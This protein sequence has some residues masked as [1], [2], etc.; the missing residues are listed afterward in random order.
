MNYYKAFHEKSV[1]DYRKLA[2]LCPP[3]TVWGVKTVLEVTATKKLSG[4]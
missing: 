2:H 4:Y 1:A 3:K